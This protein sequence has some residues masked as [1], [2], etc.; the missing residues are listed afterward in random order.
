MARYDWI[1]QDSPCRTCLRK[2][3]QVGGLSRCTDFK[4]FGG[5]AYVRGKEAA[6]LIRCSDYAGPHREKHYPGWPYF[7][8]LA[9]L[10]GRREISSEEGMEH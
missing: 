4:R 7:S 9:E 5:G 1:H 8:T 6:R 10:K 3:Y 2:E